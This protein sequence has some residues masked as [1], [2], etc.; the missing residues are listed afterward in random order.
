MKNFNRHR[1]VFYIWALFD[2]LHIAIYSVNSYRL[3][4]FPYATDFIS[5]LENISSHGGVVSG[6]MVLFSWL[7]ELSILASLI[8]FLLMKSKVKAL[9]YMQ[10]PFR[11]I[12]S[13]PSLSIML[14]FFNLFGGVSAI[15]LIIMVIMSEVLKVY[16]LKKWA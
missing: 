2:F 5:T 16:S 8:M 4:N 9:C 12:F 7:L 13:V 14:P 15:V 6:G 11:L 3:G 1:M 10:T